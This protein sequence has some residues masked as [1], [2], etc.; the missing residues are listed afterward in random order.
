MHPYLAYVLMPVLFVGL[1]MFLF[2]K[3]EYAHWIYVV[4][5]ISFV[6]KVGNIDRCNSL[7]SI[8]KRKQYYYIR[9]TENL[10]ITLPFM[11]FL[12]YKFYFVPS[13]ILLVLVV[14]MVFVRSSLP[15]NKSIPTPFRKL[16]FE[17]IVGF[18]KTFIWIILC[19]L[20]M[21]KAVHVD[22]FHLGLFAMIIA[23]LISISYYFNPESSFFTWVYSCTAREFLKT[24]IWIGLLSLTMLNVVFIVILLLAFPSMIWIIFIVQAILYLI[25]TM[26]VFAKYSAYPKQ[27]NLAQAIMF[28]LCIWFP[29]MLLIVTPLFYKQASRNLKNILE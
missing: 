16:P 15:F 10:G 13:L 9:M 22:N 8:F 21:L 6:L 27:M 29:P 19:I 1:S 11:L 2:L 3:T 4:I 23:S 7:R 28:A 20:L 5:A 24:K 18:R 26:T 14:I 12:M 17:F 25:L